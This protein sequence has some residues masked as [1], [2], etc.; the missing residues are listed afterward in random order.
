MSIPYTCYKDHVV[1]HFLP[2]IGDVSLP[3]EWRRFLSAEV[4]EYKITLKSFLDALHITHTAF[5]KRMKKV[6]EFMEWYSG[7][8]QR[9]IHIE[10]TDQSVRNSRIKSSWQSKSAEERQEVS[11]KRRSS[12]LIKY[13]CENAVTSEIVI[14]RRMATMLSKY[15]V[16]SPSKIPGV[17]EAQVEALM[18]SYG[19]DVPAKSPVVKDRIRAAIKQSSYAAIQAS[20]FSIR[21]GCSQAELL[22]NELVKNDLVLCEGSVLPS[23]LLGTSYF[24][25]LHKACGRVSEFKTYVDKPII[26]ACPYCSSNHTKFE[27]RLR[28]YFVDRGFSVPSPKLPISGHG[29]DL[30]F[31]DFGIGFEVNGGYSHCSPLEPV[32][33]SKNGLIDPKPRLYHFNKTSEA[34]LNNIRL[35][36]LWE[37]HLSF[38]LAASIIS[39]KLRILNVSYYARSLKIKAPSVQEQISFYSRNHVQGYVRSSVSYGLF[40][41][42][43]CIQMISFV[44]SGTL[45]TL[46]RNAT[47]LNTQVIGGFTRL[48]H[49]SIK[50]LRSKG[51]KQI[52]TYVNRDLTPK[53]EDSA[54]FRHGFQLVKLCYPTLSYY[55]R[56]SNPPYW[57]ANSIINRR[58]LQKHLLP[59]LFPQTYDPNLTE[60]QNLALVG[61]YPIYNSGTFTMKLLLT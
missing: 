29:I 1:Y 32:F 55:S 54:Y 42:D 15:N 20:K 3:F 49:R 31:E 47:S 19:V 56:R 57:L 4:L 5:L 33:L 10:S 43:F 58:R 16:L 14:Q 21:N 24:K 25:C 9:R 53:Y 50:E 41:G 34:L 40:Y 28:V 17:R 27:Q 39:S 7:Y 30:Y 13:G 59:K 38:E 8:P 61:I 12:N 37:D 45:A 52:V 44:L 26:S 23:N 6:P 48:F 11:L 22:A 2:P 35:Y 46:V 36:H 51:I 60:Q 18:Q